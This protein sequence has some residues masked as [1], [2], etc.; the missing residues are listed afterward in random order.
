MKR[1][2]IIMV[3]VAQA[4]I[5]PCFAETEEE[6]LKLKAE[7]ESHVLVPKGGF[8][9][10]PKTIIIESLKKEC[11]VTFHNENVLFHYGLPKVREECRPQLVEIAEALKQAF[12]DPELSQIK[13]YYVDGHTCNIGSYENNCRLSWARSSG[14][15]EALVA[16]GVPRNRLASRGFSYS[17][18]TRP[19]DTEANRQANRRVVVAGACKNDAQQPTMIPCKMAEAGIRSTPGTDYGATEAQSPQT[20]QPSEEQL[21]S[22]KGPSK[23]ALP[24][25]FNRKQPNQSSTPEGATKALPPGFKRTN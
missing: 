19:N 15:I 16:L 8:K 6:F 1:M 25:G 14:A 9:V 13:T 18:P 21:D 17:V 5:L 3:V 20:E 12:N 24:R 2:L 4:W 23:S 22:E 11:E 7:E 10:I